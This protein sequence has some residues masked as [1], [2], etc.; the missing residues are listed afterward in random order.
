MTL[1]TPPGNAT[2]ESQQSRL[3]I[4]R[5]PPTI[6]KPETLPAEESEQ[7]EGAPRGTRH[8]PS[9]WALLAPRPE[10]QLR[11]TVLPFLFC[12]MMVGGGEDTFMASP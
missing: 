1:P 12:C 8:L 7:Q 9:A 2:T 4:L 5:P 3:P 11:E 10:A 6:A